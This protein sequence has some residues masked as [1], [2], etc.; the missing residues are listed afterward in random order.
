M[1]RFIERKRREGVG[2]FTFVLLVFCGSILLSIAGGGKVFAA[3]EA[4]EV[5][6][7]GIAGTW[8]SAEKE[9]LAKQ[10]E[11]VFKGA[12]AKPEKDIIA[13]ILPH[14]GYQYS[15]STAAAGLRRLE[16]RYKR[17][18]VIGPSHRIGME[19]MLCV[20]RAA[21]IETP[22]GKIP[23]DLAFINKLLK[24]PIFQQ[25]PDVIQNE[26]S[27]QIELPLLQKQLGSF[28][29]VLIVAGQCSQE[30]IKRGAEI[31]KGLV[32][33]DTLVVVSSD[34]THYG[35]SYRYVP[36]KDNIP[37]KLKELDMGAYK[38][39]EA[40]DSSGFLRYIGDTGDTICGYVPIAI[41]LSMADKGTK[42]ELV[43]YATSGSMSG[44]F[45]Q[46]VSYCAIAMKGAW[47]QVAQ[48]QQQ[49]AS[50]KLSEEDK[51][52][53]LKLAR[54]TIEYCLRKRA[55][56]EANELGVAVSEAMKQP[57]AAF[58]TLTKNK[59]LRGCIGDI[60]PRQ[61]LYKSVMANAINAAINDTRFKSME[62]SECNDISIEISAL[63]VPEPVKSAKDIRI[64]ID[65][66]ILSKSGRTAVFL[67]QVAVEQHWGLEEMLSNL[68][69]KAGLAADAWKEGAKF[70][71][72][73]AEVF[74][75]KE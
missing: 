22:L 25:F 59:M 62:I 63:T 60:F 18:I 66:V 9:A 27:T 10:V 39:I 64:G 12:E 38:K 70:L 61:P 33:E 73:Q 5:L 23:Q 24:Y 45:S 19:E 56:P 16:N 43:K 50:G 7:S 14:A 31:L 51:K 67:P 29:V 30:T 48:A 41:L 35:Q 44:D 37:E 4:G 46:S 42:V 52:V 47:R 6:R 11:D 49:P 69:E 1:N 36:F 54:K 40:L 2:A 17:V 32:D 34:F 57:R 26:H 55:V 71:V 28:D 58:V 68:S 75:E 20:A 21:Q 13:L 74:G 72:F 8:Y 3:G 65:G 53:L 15:G